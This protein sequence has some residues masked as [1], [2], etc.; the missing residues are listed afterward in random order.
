MI[1]LVA[2]EE[3]GEEEEGEEGEERLYGRHPMGPTKKRR[4]AIPNG[5]FNNTRPHY[6]K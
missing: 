4:M 6:I 5:N 1:G 3:E 2:G